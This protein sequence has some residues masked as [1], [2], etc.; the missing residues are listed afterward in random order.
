MKPRTKLMRARD[1]DVREGCSGVNSLL[2]EEEGGKKKKRR[3]EEKG[4]KSDHPLRKNKKEN[5]S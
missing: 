5:L 3:K 2:E 4:S 1:S